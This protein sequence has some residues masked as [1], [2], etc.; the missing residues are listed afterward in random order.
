[1]STNSRT[2]CRDWDGVKISGG[3]P[4]AAWVELLVYL[5]ATPWLVRRTVWSSVVWI[6]LVDS[7]LKIGLE[8]GHQEIAEEG[9]EEEEQAR[10]K[11][12]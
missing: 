5:A 3:L 2:S 12:N 8:H 10:R 6:R 4:R 9:S 11:E 1:M 7:D